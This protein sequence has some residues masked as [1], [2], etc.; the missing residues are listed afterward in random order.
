MLSIKIHRLCTHCLLLFEAV[1]VVTVS[2]TSCSWDDDPDPNEPQA[3]TLHGIPLY[4]PTLHGLLGAGLNAQLAMA[5]EQ[6]HTPPV[7][8]DPAKLAIAVQWKYCHNGPSSNPSL[9]PSPQACV[10]TILHLPVLR[11]RRYC[12]APGQIYGI[13]NGPI[14][15]VSCS[16]S[17]LSS[18][19]SCL[20][21]MCYT[22]QQETGPSEYVVIHEK[23]RAWWTFP[24]QQTAPNIQQQHLEQGGF[25]ASIGHP[26]SNRRVRRLAS[27]RH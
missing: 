25:T 6:L 11:R 7:H 8:M 27:R 17:S 5:R 14:T 23:R 22:W 26:P 18:S 21:L 10:A 9:C 24:R 1:M 20:L 19:S 13:A 12:P 2:C 3:W 16:I 4:A 15:Q